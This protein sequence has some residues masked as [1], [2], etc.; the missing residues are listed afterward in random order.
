MSSTAPAIRTRVPR[1]AEAALERARLTVVPK[2]KRRRTSPVPFMILVSMLAV[3]GVVG[4]LLFNTSM[5]QASF[6]ATDLQNQADV[7]QARQQSLQMELARL[8]DPQ[9]IAMKAQ[10]MGMVLPT[11]PAVLDLRNGKV[12]GDPTP[13]TR[14]D[15]LRL[16]APPPVKPAELDPPAHV[17]VVHTDST[18]SGD[19]N[20]SGNTT[21]RSHDDGGRAGRNDHTSHTSNSN[22]AGHSGNGQP[23]RH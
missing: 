11:S 3:G 19:R 21:R 4:L 20:S 5:Q 9:T 12:L 23:D 7:L 13:A 17:T 1:L 16:V 14:L 6:A 10:R 2:R 15:P 18:G 22:N 8:R